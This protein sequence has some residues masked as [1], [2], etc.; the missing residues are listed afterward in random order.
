M[1]ILLL[2]ELLLELLDL[3]PSHLELLLLL[4]KLLALL[5]ELLVVLLALLLLV[6]ALTL[7][8]FVLLLELLVLLLEELILLQCLLEELV[9][10][11][12]VGGRMLLLS[13]FLLCRPC[14]TIVS[15]RH[16]TSGK[17][18]GISTSAMEYCKGLKGG[19][20]VRGGGR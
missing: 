19:G 13:F 6:V 9:V 11:K 10:R 17:G 7:E 12:R 15:R 20:V 1:V 14:P 3:L 16:P 2:V 18:G 8:G 4:L 5:L